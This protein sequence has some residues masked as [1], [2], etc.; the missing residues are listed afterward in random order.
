MSSSRPVAGVL[1]RLAPHSLRGKIVAS[2]VALMAVAMLVVAFGIQLLLGFQTQRDIDRV[3]DGKAASTETVIEQASSTS[4]TVPAD[5]LEPGVVVY[6][7]AGNRVA[8]SIQT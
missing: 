3:L 1:S 6:D 7:S 5:G 4:L 2:T 8:G